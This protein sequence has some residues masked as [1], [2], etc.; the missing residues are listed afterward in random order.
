MDCGEGTVV[1]DRLVGQRFELLFSAAI[2][3]RT[4]ISTFIFGQI[5][6]RPYWSRGMSF[7][8]KHNS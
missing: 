7:I 6:R 1:A 2:P 8:L 5:A 4:V 3:I